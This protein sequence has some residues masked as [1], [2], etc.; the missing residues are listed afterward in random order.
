MLKIL[1]L[2]IFAAHI[3]SQDS[4]ILKIS[5]NNDRDEVYDTLNIVYQID[6]N[7][8]EYSLND[9]SILTYIKDANNKTIHF[10]L[11]LTPSKS[12]FILPLDITNLKL[13][14]NDFYQVVGVLNSNKDSIE[15]NSFYT[16][17]KIEKIERKVKLDKYGRM[18]VNNQL[19][20][21]SWN[22]Y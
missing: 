12:L 8:G 11:K 10:L 16:F 18:F 1:Y 21:L 5:I 17:K 9:F 3:Y 13:K 19:F 22:L 15:S 2:L 14:E 20:F 6:Y 7:I 4:D